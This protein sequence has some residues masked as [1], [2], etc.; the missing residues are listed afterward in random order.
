MVSITHIVNPVKVPE[1][2]DLFRAQPITFDSMRRA[3]DFVGNAMEINLIST[4]YNED[5]EIIPDYFYKTPNLNRSVLD[6]GSFQENK[7]LP[8]LQDIFTKAVAWKPDADYIIYTNVDIALYPDFYKKVITLIE[9]GYDGICINR[10]TLPEEACQGAT[11]ESLYTIKGLKHEGIDCFIIKRDLLPKFDLEHSI[12]G[13]GPVGLVIAN[14]LLHLAT[15]FIWIREGRY[16][17][18][19][20]DDKSWL[21]DDVTERSQLYFS[22]VQFRKILINLLGK[23]KDSLKEIILNESL[24]MANSFL[25]N[26]AFVPGFQY[27]KMLQLYSDGDFAGISKLNA[28]KERKKTPIANRL[29]TI[30]KNYTKWTK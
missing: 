26:K 29:K 7:K 28:I 10:N 1:S 27:R 3:K 5:C 17:F 12:I 24:K 9:K 18:H 6:V 22:F 13:T 20:G 16:T 15:K 14:N 25:E 23:E 2:S 8:F 21:L 30:F 11:L 4:Q 19:I